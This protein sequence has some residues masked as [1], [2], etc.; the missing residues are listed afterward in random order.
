MVLTSCSDGPARYLHEQP[1]RGAR[2]EKRR[3]EKHRGNG[4]WDSK[5][6]AALEE[7]QWQTWLIESPT[8]ST[9]VA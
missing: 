8:C 6:V 4:Y 9:V 5:L 1:A 3:R 2:R 7:M